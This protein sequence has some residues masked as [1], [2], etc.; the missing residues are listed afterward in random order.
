[1]KHELE[2]TGIVV[3]YV[4]DEG[5]GVL[6]GEEKHYNLIDKWPDADIVI[7]T[8][9]FGFEEIKNRILNNNKKLNVFFVN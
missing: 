9:I 3:S 2:K 5:E 6:Y 8:P 4:V 1:M 7:V